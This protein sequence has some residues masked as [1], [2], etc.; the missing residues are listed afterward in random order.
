MGL[1]LQSHSPEFEKRTQDIGSLHHRCSTRDFSIGSGVSKIFLKCRLQLFN[2]DQL[3]VD[4]IGVLESLVLVSADLKTLDGKFFAVSVVGQTVDHESR[5][6]CPHHL[7]LVDGLPEWE[8]DRLRQ[9][10]PCSIK[11]RRTVQKISPAILYGPSEGLLPRFCVCDQ[12]GQDQPVRSGWM[13]RVDRL[14]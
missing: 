1:R 4:A 14:R 9:H 5:P 6:N 11:L 2:R 3:V 10:S 12:R 8:V 13:R 7:Q